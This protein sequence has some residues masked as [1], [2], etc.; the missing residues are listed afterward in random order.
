MRELK[1]GREAYV[2]RAWKEAHASLSRADELGSLGAE[3]LV[4][5]AV[6]AY[7]LGRD[8][9]AWALLERAHHAYTEAGETLRAVRC[10]FWIGLNLTLRGETGPGGGW[11]ARA[12]RLLDRETRDCAERGYMLLPLAFRQEA[13]G[14]WEAAAATA[15]SAAEIA[16]RFGDEDLF[17]LATQV[18]GRVLVMHARVAEGLRLLDEAMVAATS[19]AK[20]PII[21]GV[22]Y[23]GVILACVETQEVR[24]AAE[25]TEVLTRWC[26]AQPELLA[27]T[28]RCRIHRAEILQLRGDWRDA[29]DE[30]RR[31][32]ERLAGGF[33]RPA[34]AQAFY[35]QGEL[36][37]LRGE[38][39]PA[40]EA[41]RAAS[42]YG[43]EPQPGLALLRLAQ[44]RIETSAAAMRRILGEVADRP[45]RAHLLPAFVEI[46]LAVHELEAAQE[47]CLELEEIAQQYGS[48]ML[49]ATAAHASGAVRLTG[50]DASGALAVLR[51]ASQAWEELEAPYETARTRVLLGLACR[52]LG[53]DETATFEL[54][55]ARETFTELGAA[56]EIRRVDSL[57]GESEGRDVRGLTTRELEVLRLVAAGTSNRGIAATLVISEHTV[58]RHLQNIFAK[59]GVSSRTA[60]SAFA[61]EHDLI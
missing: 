51:S 12:Q 21:T 28:G 39:A 22:V 2:R 17:A 27:F 5:L 56:P 15:A 58:A 48:T 14:D 9:D 11:L 38:L 37:R 1:H 25:W 32:Q 31:A 41:Y 54:A 30:A 7:M 60:A 40:E 16:E 61:Y 36:H 20:S 46:M 35:R 43:F 23:C 24:R 53:D 55:A 6:S 50:G 49:I 3:D 8:D 19:G 45:R 47:A 34:T 44:G 13:G 33:N 57:L 10:A 26:E 4:L 29:L 42:R 52:E 18:H 59:L